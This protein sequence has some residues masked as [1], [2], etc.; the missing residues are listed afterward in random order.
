MRTYKRVSYDETGLLSDRKRLREDV[1]IPW[2]KYLRENPD[3]QGTGY[4]ERN[5]K[6]CC[7]GVLCKIQ[8]RPFTEENGATVFDLSSGVLS[9]SNPLYCLLE[10]NGDLGI[11]VDFVGEGLSRNLATLN[12]WGATF[13]EIAWL[14][15]EIL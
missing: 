1:K 13:D 4:L 7:L 12:D 9:P 3:K 11:P 5:G 14:I 8:N 6:M 2:I 15:E 10:H